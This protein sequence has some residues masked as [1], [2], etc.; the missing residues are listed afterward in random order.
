M[1]FVTHWPECIPN[2]ATSVGIYRWRTISFA[3][4]DRNLGSN[5]PALFNSLN[6]FSFDIWPDLETLVIPG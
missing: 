4:P 2:Q 6:D 5:D 3:K 1:I